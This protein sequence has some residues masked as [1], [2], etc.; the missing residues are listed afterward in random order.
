MVGIAEGTA[1]A[2]AVS[3]ELNVVDVVVCLTSAFPAMTPG[4]AV[5][6]RADVAVVLLKSKANMIKKAMSAAT[7]GIQGGDDG[8]SRTVD[9]TRIT[10]IEQLTGFLSRPLN[11]GSHEL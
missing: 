7:E 11:G 3:G 1:D 4:D 9:R 2:E 6:M 10:S 8:V 5:R